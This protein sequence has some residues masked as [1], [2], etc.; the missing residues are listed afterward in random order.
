M[1][2]EYKEEI[3]EDEEEKKQDKEEMKKV[4]KEK[5]KKDTGGGNDTDCV[6]VF[7]ASVGHKNI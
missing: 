6:C 3:K 7:A 5:I 4:G 2:Q 1:K